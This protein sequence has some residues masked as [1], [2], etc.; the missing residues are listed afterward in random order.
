MRQIT[1]AI[2]A[3]VL[4]AT[5]NAGA[6][7]IERF[8]LDNQLRV[9]LR[10]LEGAST[11]A[12]V[13][14]FS[15]GERH[16]PVGVSGM[17]HLM[18]HLL[19]TAAAGDI[20]AR[21]A[22]SWSASYRPPTGGANAQTGED[23]TV[24]ATVFPNVQLDDE[25]TDLASRLRGLTIT[26]ADLD[27]E[28]PRLDT[29]LTNMFAGIPSLASM[30][31]ARESI[32]PSGDGFRKGGLI[33]QLR[34]VTVEQTQRFA[35]AYYKPRNALIVIAGGFD[36]DAARALVE[37]HFANIESGDQLPPMRDIRNRADT[38][39]ST[40]PVTAAEWYTGDPIVITRAYA[41]PAPDSPQYAPFLV[42]VARLFQKGMASYKPGGV[43]SVQC[44]L[45]D[46]PFVLYVAASV[47]S[48]DELPAAR[49]GLDELIASATDETQE[50][51][52]DAAMVAMQF[53]WMFGSTDL[54][55]AMLANNPYGVA[56]GLGRAEMMGIDWSALKNRL[57]ALTRQDMSGAAGSIF[58]ADN[59]AEVVVTID[60]DHP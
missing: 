6:A 23:Y 1:R 14:L 18:E 45:I 56:L 34:T 59:R 13:T 8:N 28:L 42:H 25:L 55:D 32:R 49:V 37:K 16:D 24:L 39:P 4:A 44:A 35:D 48:E 30:N 46:D 50:K 47:A 7:T 15:V 54:P 10:P 33:E 21:T 40:I 29:E 57:G 60:R 58:A 3:L 26:Q 38:P 31:H 22:E 19:V 41:V 9:I 20:P 5:A 11:T 51:P 43:P 17:A 2:A 12:L 53:G 52:G 27:R 36:T